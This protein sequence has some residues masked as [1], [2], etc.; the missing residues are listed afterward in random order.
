MSPT[1]PVSLPGSS[2]LTRGKL[3]VGDKRVDA[4]GL[5]PAHAGKTTGR[6]ACRSAR[7]A[8]PR[9]R[10]ENRERGASLGG[11]A[12][13]SPL[14][15]GKLLTITAM[16]AA[17]GLIPAHAGKTSTASPQRP[18]S[19]AHPRSRGENHLSACVFRRRHGSSPLTRGK[20]H[21]PPR[22]AR[23]CGLIPAH[24]GKT[25]ARRGP[26]PES[27]AHPRSRGENQIGLDEAGHGVGSS[28]LTRGKPPRPCPTRGGT[29]LIP[30]HA[31]KTRWCG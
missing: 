24:A 26:P 12:G 2:P 28:P 22:P 1:P 16:I 5:I 25:P 14:T 7:W 31:G 21:R 4:R 23:P 6:A 17:L 27:R 20:P 10:G 29:G 9:S 19:W 8:H 18:S 30:A 11:V 15:R 13:S 3:H